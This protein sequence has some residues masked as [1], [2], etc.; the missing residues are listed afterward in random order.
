[1]VRYCLLSTISQI[2]PNVAW[3]YLYDAFEVSEGKEGEQSVTE[4]SMIRGEMKCRLR[5]YCPFPHPRFYT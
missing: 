3:I 4:S 2:N 5:G 1:M